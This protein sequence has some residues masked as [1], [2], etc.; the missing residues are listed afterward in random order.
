[1]NAWICLLAAA[2]CWF[3]SP[4]MSQASGEVPAHLALAREIVDKVAPEHNRYR[5]GGRTVRVPGSGNDAYAVEADCTGFLLALLQQAGYP[6]EARMVLLRPGP[7]R[8]RP[9][10]EDFVLSIEQEKGFAR[11]E[12]IDRVRPGDLLAHAMLKLEDQAATQ[13]TGHVFLIDAAPRRIP[14]RNPVVPGT[15]QYEVRIIDTNDEVV[16]SDDSRLSRSGKATGAGKGTIRVYT[17]PEGRLVGWARTFR[18]ARFFS[19][20]PRFPSDT[21]LRKAAIGRP[22]PG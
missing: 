20:D 22:S 9:R 7:K 6:T 14:P 1:V 12:R 4:A 10:A 11:I 19:Y 18:D 8:K 13:T 2:T 5:L 15:T 16:G 3:A 17:D 21:K